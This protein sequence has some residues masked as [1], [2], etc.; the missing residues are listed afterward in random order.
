MV[1]DRLDPRLVTAVSLV[2]QAAA[3]LTILQTDA[4]SIVLAACAVFGLSVGNLI[5]LPPLIIHREF[6]PAS[7]AVVMGLSSAISGTVGA[8]GPA[9]V[10][11][12]RG[13]SGDYHAALALCVALELSAAAIVVQQRPLGWRPASTEGRG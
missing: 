1:I 9:I 5:T 3:L 4:V 6:S 10:G 13:W 11:L 7:F 12:V 2:S 8:L